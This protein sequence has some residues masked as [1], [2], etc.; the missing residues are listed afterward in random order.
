M[1]QSRGLHYYFSMRA[2][3]RLLPMR[4]PLTVFVAAACV[5]GAES[6]GSAAAKPSQ[7]NV[8]IILTDDQGSVDAGCYG[9]KDLVTP[10]VDA[11][12]AHGVRFTQFY[13]AA[14]VC[15][16]SRAG[17]MTGR[18]PWLAGMPNNGPSPPA[19]ADDQLETLTGAGLP[20]KEITL[21][22]MFRDAGYATA[23]IGKWHLGSGAGHK[24][25]DHGF[26]YSFG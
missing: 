9:A 13:S 25:L 14:P 16:P 8:V 17:L 5:A 4:Y 24:P 15:S 21:A 20:A 22:K 6:S 10:G 12:A 18:Y 19:E 23:H 3:F 2:L 11:L 7:P 1:T 26:D